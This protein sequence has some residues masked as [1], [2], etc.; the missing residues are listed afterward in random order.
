MKKKTS[1]PKSNAITR[2]KKWQKE[3]MRETGKE[4]NSKGERKIDKRQR[5]SPGI[6]SSLSPLYPVL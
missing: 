5:K 3:K 6:P 4:N 1:K 2:E